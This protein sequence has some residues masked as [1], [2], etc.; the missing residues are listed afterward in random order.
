VSVVKSFLL[1]AVLAFTFKPLPLSAQNVL[2]IVDFSGSMKRMVGGRPMITVAK[3][4]FRNTLQDIPPSTKVALML[5]GHRR[6]KDCRDIELVSRLGQQPALALADQ[7][8]KLEAKGE[9]PIATSLLQA[10]GVFSGQKGEKNSVVLI[11]DGKEE[12]NGDPCAA[13]STLAA[14]GLDVNV[15]V[16]G[17]RLSE[18]QRQS[19][20]CISANTGGRYFDAQD[21]SALKSALVSVR[22]SVAQVAPSPV[23]PPAPPPPKQE[24]LNLLATRNGGEII[25]SPHERWTGSND[26]RLDRVGSDPRYAFKPG[27]EA[28]YGFRAGSAASLEAF[29]IYVPA[30]SSSTPKEIELFA[31][32]DGPGGPFRAIGVMTILNAKLRDG[33]QEFKLPAGTTAKY[34]KV[35]LVSSHGDGMEIYEFRLYG[36]FAQADATRPATP[37]SAPRARANILSQKQGGEIIVSPH[38]RWAGSNDDQL[39]RVGSDPRYAFKPGDEAVYA[40][41][42]ERA[43]SLEAFAIYVPATSSSTPKEI[44]LFASD[45]GPAG[46]FKSLGIVTTVN[47]KVRDGWQELKLPSGTTAKYV[48][49][50]LISSHGDDGMEI[51]EFQLFGEMK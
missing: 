35:R 3:E 4:V 44:E 14:A 29:A 13:A 39:S 20:A 1:I 22:E 6:A 37:A 31:G 51:Y 38:E 42:G 33:W 49:V 2:F 27:D 12:C 46:P 45:E 21:A 43:A 7:I 17:F 30:T 19:V 26:D 34:F 41:R 15:H 9:T 10:V 24:R 16:V 48:K 28:A 32:D 50:K 36:E 23:P 47:A 40:F 8:D 25:V 5:Y 18:E 11:T